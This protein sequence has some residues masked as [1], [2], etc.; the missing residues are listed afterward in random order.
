[1]MLST[2]II[3]RCD[4]AQWLEIINP[5]PLSMQLMLNETYGAIY[6]TLYLGSILHLKKSLVW[7]IIYLIPEVD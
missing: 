4:N 5:L 1:M 6:L 7:Q 3:V 2:D